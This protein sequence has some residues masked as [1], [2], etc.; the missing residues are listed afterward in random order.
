MKIFVSG[1]FDDKLFI[2]NK[3]NELQDLGYEITFDWTSFEDNTVNKSI[4]TL[5]AI[6]DIDGVKNCDV[7]IIIISD[8]DYIYRG[9]FTEL[10]C[11]LGLNKKILIWCPFE[12]AFCMSN[13]FYYHP[14]IRHFNDWNLCLEF[15]KNLTF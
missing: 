2:K 15:L 6:N 1:K 13:P 11:S 4:A 5:A 12:D 9:T 10:G 7:H 3:I 8:K 14:S